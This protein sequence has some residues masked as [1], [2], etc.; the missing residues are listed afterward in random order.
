M[1]Y[2]IQNA[3]GFEVTEGLNLTSKAQSLTLKSD[4]KFTWVDAGLSKVPQ[5]S[6]MRFLTTIGQVFQKEYKSRL[7]SW[8][9][10]IQKA[11]NKAEEAIDK[12][13]KVFEK[14][15]KKPPPSGKQIEDFVTAQNKLRME[16][17]KKVG[18]AA[19]ASYKKMV[20]GLIKPVL[21]K[22]LKQMSDVSKLFKN[23]K[24]SLAWAVIKFV[25]SAV[26][27]TAAAIGIAATGGTGAAVVFAV[28]A[29][30]VKSLSM[31]KDTGTK[32]KKFCSAYE[33]A[34]IKVDAE[35]KTASTTVD[36]AI[37]NMR[38][39]QKARDALVVQ[40]G[41]ATQKLEDA[42]KK[43]A[44]DTSHKDLKKAMS[45]L[46]KMQAAIVSFESS[47][48]GNPDAVLSQLENARKALKDTS[49]HIPAAV[50]SGKSTTTLGKIFDK[51]ND[52]VS[53]IAS[54]VD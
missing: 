47:I 17:T 2:A 54:W 39:A 29:V 38:I 33:K 41:D 34:M 6:A 51:I 18:D 36:N 12:K 45:E 14:A 7:S 19:E 37:A 31:I 40:L 28:G 46:K 4:I 49:A 24:G 52:T 42:Q 16:A 8:Q 1:K 20:D 23:S 50:T 44:G 15:G 48:G 10:S 43:A 22:T 21:A 27:L 11:L 35:I 30:V 9:D 53:Q 3:K 5:D 25:A 13:T 32:I 26:T